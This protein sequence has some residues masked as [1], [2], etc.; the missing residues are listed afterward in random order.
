MFEI[1]ISQVTQ[2]MNC[3]EAKRVPVSLESHDLPLY[4][5][6]RD[7]DYV[8]DVQLNCPGSIKAYSGER[9]RV[10]EHRFFTSRSA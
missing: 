7:R 1:E 8:H 3:L 10:Y 6:I 4:I 5:L 2:E 9:A